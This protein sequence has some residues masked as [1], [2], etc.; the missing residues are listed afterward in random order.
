MEI[1]RH[2]EKSEVDSAS[3]KSK[4]LGQRKQV[5]HPHF[6]KS[7]TVEKI[8][9][10]L[11]KTFPGRQSSDKLSCDRV[12][13]KMLTVLFS[14]CIYMLVPRD[15]DKSLA[16]PGRKQATATEDFDFHISSL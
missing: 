15:A 3:L 1:E 7:W 11:T 14:R 5:P 4:T 9:K 16:Q 12:S 8:I 2:V 10:D 13:F 6:T